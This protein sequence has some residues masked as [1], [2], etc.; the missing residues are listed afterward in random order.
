MSDYVLKKQDLDS[1]AKT[2]RKIYEP[3]IWEKGLQ[4]P[5]E[6]GTLL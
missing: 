2:M 4:K 5:D 1:V 3:L 6:K